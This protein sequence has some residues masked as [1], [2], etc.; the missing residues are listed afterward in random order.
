MDPSLQWQDPGPHPPGAEA[1]IEFVHAETSPEEWARLP[2]FWNTRADQA[3]ALLGM[4][5]LTGALAAAQ[6][7]SSVRIKVPLGLDDPRPFVPASNPLTVDKW[8]LGRRLFF[9]DTW[10]EARAGVSCAGC[11]NPQ[12]GFTDRRRTHPDGFNAPT[13]LNVVYNRYQFWDGRAGLL[14]EVV[15]RSLKDEYE[16]PP[17]FQHTWSGAVR[18]LRDNTSCQYQFDQV[19]HTPPTQDAVGRALATYLRTLLAGNSLHD[20]ARAVMA[21]KGAPSLE[22]A[23]YEAVLDDAA[24]ADLGRVRVDKAEVARELHRGYTLFSDTRKER[25]TN[26]V[27]CHSGRQFTDGDFHNLGVGPRSPPLREGSRFA[28]VPIGRK[29]GFLIGAYKTPT[30]RSLPRTGP[31]LHDGSAD[32]L[33]QVV[34]HHAHRNLYLDPKMLDKEDHVRGDDLK[35]EEVEALVLFLR[36]LNGDEVDAVLRKPS[37]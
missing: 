11:H 9:D 16:D 37:P 28:A 3:A 17:T 26:C 5:S 24:L 21:K 25:R 35:P 8:K 14:E 6:P 31:Y 36:A 23:H 34:E 7:A 1:H 12:E 22:P 2:Q 19:F 4:P 15:Q 18:R 10:L 32:D 33:G 30:L 20:R 29:D 27:D 13:L